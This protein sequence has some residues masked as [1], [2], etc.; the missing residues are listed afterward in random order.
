MEP[1]FARVRLAD[2]HTFRRQA[3]ITVDLLEEPNA[4]KAAAS[5]A[6]LAA[7]AA[8]DAACAAA[9]GQTWK[10]E[11]TQAST[12]L[13]EVTGGAVAA[14]ALGRIVASKTNWQYLEQSVTDAILTK[15]LRQADTVIEFAEKVVLRR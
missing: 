12:L 15:A 13:R 9:L 7:I 5:S 6:V 3:Q 14:Q 4:R 8:A 10:G 1:S 11:H 2:A